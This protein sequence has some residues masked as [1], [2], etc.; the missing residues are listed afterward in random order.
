MLRLPFF[1]WEVDFETGY[2]RFQ[3]LLLDAFKKE[4]LAALFVN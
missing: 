4:E 2:T 3:Q 1:D